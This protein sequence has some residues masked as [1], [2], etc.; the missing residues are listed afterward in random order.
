MKKD[1]HDFCVKRE[2]FFS[3][4]RGWKAGGS[5]YSR[6]CVPYKG[7]SQSIPIPDLTLCAAYL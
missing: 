5:F 1:E 6:H 7:I 3:Y 2:Y 4:C